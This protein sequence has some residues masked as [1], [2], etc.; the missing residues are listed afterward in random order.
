MNVYGIMLSGKQGSGKTT[1]ANKLK[2]WAD[3]KGIPFKTVKFAGTLYEMHDAIK[4]IAHKKG[5]PMKEKDGP[6]L[7]W[8][9][10]EW[11]R[12]GFG[13][14]VWVNATKTEIDGIIKH[15][16]KEGVDVMIVVD[17]CRFPNELEVFKHFLTVRLSADRDARKVRADAWRDNENHQSETALDEFEYNFDLLLDTVDHP[18]EEITKTIIE[19]MLLKGVKNAS[20]AT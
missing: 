8:L 19:F 11:G 12:N 15:Y 6:F 1:T 4:A 17:D 2:E 13:E 14:N 9:G 10:T 18:P 16:E 7:Q 3:K 5:I 20:A